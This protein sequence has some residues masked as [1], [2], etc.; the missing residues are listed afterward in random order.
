MIMRRAGYSA[1][2][3]DR[4]LVIRDGSSPARGHA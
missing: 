4:L 2:L 1:T 3:R